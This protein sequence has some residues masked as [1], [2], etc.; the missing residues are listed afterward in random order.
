MM[1]L[2]L[3]DLLLIGAVVSVCNLAMVYLG[4][5]R[6]VSKIGPAIDLFGLGGDGGE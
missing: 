5:R 6:L 1:S 4:V 2:T 3:L